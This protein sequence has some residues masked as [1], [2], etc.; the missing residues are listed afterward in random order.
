MAPTQRLKQ[1]YLVQFE[2]EE[3]PTSMVEVDCLVRHYGTNSKVEAKLLS[4]IG[5]WIGTD[6][7]G[8]RKL[9]SA[10]LWHQLEGWSKIT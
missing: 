2:I 3:A 8:R 10:A 9:L 6:Y 5:N 1:N 4:A 7:F